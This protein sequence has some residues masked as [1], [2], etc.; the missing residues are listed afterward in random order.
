MRQRFQRIAQTPAEQNLDDVG[1]KLNAGADLAERRRALQQPSIPACARK[2]Q[3]GG[4]S[5]DTAASHY[6]T[7]TFIHRV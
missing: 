2:R 1:S 3:C 6:H 5:A 7:P 4:Q